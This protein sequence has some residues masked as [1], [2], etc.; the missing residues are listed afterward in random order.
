MAGKEPLRSGKT[1]GGYK[2]VSA[3]AQGKRASPFTAYPIADLISDHGPQDAE[4][5]GVSYVEV[6]LVSHCASGYEDSFSR[7]WD[8]SALQQHSK[9]DNQ[10]SVLSDQGED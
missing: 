5:D 10:V 6:P 8:P 9:E 7:E 2:N 4:Y 3:P 1:L